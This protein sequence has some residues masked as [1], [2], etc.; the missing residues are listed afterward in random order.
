MNYRLVLQ[1]VYY[2]Y[3]L[4]YGKFYGKG[5]LSAIIKI[6]IATVKIVSFSLTLVLFS[7]FSS[8]FTFMPRS[9]RSAAH[10]GGGSKLNCK[11]LPC[12]SK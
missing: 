4:N 5:L 8:I 1:G 3:P 12:I 7:S 11:A 2:F 6:P 9:S 10:G